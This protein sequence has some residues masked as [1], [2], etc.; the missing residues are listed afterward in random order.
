[1]HIRGASLKTRPTLSTAPTLTD[2]PALINSPRPLSVHPSA[3]KP[4]RLLADSLIRPDAPGLG[5]VWQAGPNVNPGGSLSRSYIWGNT[6]TPLNASTNPPNNTSGT[7]CSD[8]YATPLSADNMNAQATLSNL[9]SGT[10]QT[11]YATYIMIRGNATDCI[12]AYCFTGNFGYAIGT[13]LSGTATDR[14]TATTGTVASGT[15]VKL[16]GVGNL[17]TLYV[18]GSSVLTWTDSGN[19]FTTGPTRR[20]C[21]IAPFC[22]YDGTTATYGPGWKNFTCGVL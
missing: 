19:V 20:Q 16:T 15:A 22:L 5:H 17:Y 8:I 18:G 12:Y 21:G 14:V 3:V 2:Y 4:Y 6:A 13:L 10:T 9:P 1:M 11:G 7:A